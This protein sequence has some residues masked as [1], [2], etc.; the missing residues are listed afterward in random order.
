MR[1]FLLDKITEYVPGESAKG[2]KCITL[3]D[4]VVHDHFPD[5]PLLP[6][7]L[8]LEG[9][10]QLAGWLLESIFNKTD[11]DIKRA[12]FVQAD[13]IKFYAKSEPGDVL[14]YHVTIKHLLEDAGKIEFTAHSKL[15]GEL[16]A[17]G[18]ITFSMAEATLKK[19]LTAQRHNLYS[20]WTKGLENCP[21]IR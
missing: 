16:K 15:S 4:P 1:Y 6:G 2:L 8:I 10:A 11:D 12:L 19:N 21:P 5:I 13:K 17:K 18:M 3:T 20:I 9:C 7:A 14:E